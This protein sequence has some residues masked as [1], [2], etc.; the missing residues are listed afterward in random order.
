M[1]PNTRQPVLVTGASGFLGGSLVRQLI[2]RQDRVCCLVRPTSDSVQLKSSG[3]HLIVG[4]VTDPSS[5]ARALAESA[6]GTV[7]HLAG[8]VRARNRDEFMRVNSTGV[9]VV[10]AAC[11]ACAV[12]PVLVVVSSLAA[13]GPCATDRFRSESDIPAP[14]S[15]YGRSKLAGEQAAAG[16]AGR[17]PITIVRPP[18]VFGPG[19]RAV[20]EVFTPIARW[21]IHAVP[22]LRGGDRRVSLV[23]VDD[24]AEG[25]LLAAAKGERLQVRGPLGQ[26]VYFMGGEDHPTYADFGHRIATALGRPL[27][28]VIRV[29]GP[30]L[31]LLGVGGDVISLARR[32]A[33]W[34]NSD[35]MTEALC[36]GSW[37]CSSAKAR[38]QL[39]W[40]QAAASLDDRLHETAE[41]Y[42]KAGW[43]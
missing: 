13:A 23:H 28:T 8:L 22:G 16:Y 24:L 20:L 26:G 42:R 5:V 35:K 40:S 11:A 32:R 10:A 27:A 36:A 12:P 3:A 31:K 14:I 43:L 37:T 30:I 6:A 38:E 1:A 9:E 39:G 25:L 21:G 18:I 2:E 4:D 34:I 29:P 15:H 7:F 33:S 17:V 41:W 19:D